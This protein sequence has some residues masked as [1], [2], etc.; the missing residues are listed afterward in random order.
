[1]TRRGAVTAAARAGRPVSRRI[2]PRPARP[3]A[4]RDRADRRAGPGV[5]QAAVRRSPR[6]ASPSASR[7]WSPSSRSRTAAG[8]APGRPRPA[9]HQH[10][11]R[12]AGPVVPGRRHGPARRG[13]R[14]DP[15]GSARSRRRARR[16]RSRR[17]SAGP[18]SSAGGETNG[19]SRPGRGP[20]A[21]R[22]A[23]AARSARAASWTRPSSVPG[24]RARLRG[25]R[26]PRDRGPRRARPG[27]D[28]R[29]LVHGRRHPGP[30]P[31][32][33]ELDRAALIGRDAA[34][35]WLEA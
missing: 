35:T 32:A 18:I 16:R 13:A 10:A 4:D 1:M 34:A 17:P 6:W 24:R 29:P 23:R 33:P 28:R 31:L 15:R 7:R 30:L 5:P 12:L 3:R 26:A 14:D 27:V 11:H 8:L 20:L 21:P 2:R 25:R 9:G 22:D 19:L